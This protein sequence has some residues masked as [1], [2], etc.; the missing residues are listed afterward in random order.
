[1]RRSKNNSLAI[2]F[3]RAGGD[4][5]A[6]IG[7]EGGGERDGGIERLADEEIAVVESCGEDRYLDFSLA[8][9]P[10]FYISE[11]KAGETR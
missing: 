2:E 8:R 4:H 1:M 11:F 9:S 6:A 5:S 10:R 3:G 7:E